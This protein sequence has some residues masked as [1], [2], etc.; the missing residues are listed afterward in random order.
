MFLITSNIRLSRL[1]PD[2]HVF[3]TPVM[4]TSANKKIDQTSNNI[5]FML[6]K[7]FALLL[8]LKL[9]FSLRSQAEGSQSR[10]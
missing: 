2:N 1:K 7:T 8:L 3:M 6:M 5:L 4:G 10:I 9:G